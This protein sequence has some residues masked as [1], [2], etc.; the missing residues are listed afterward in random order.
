MTAARVVLAPT[1]LQ[2]AH[3]HL[4]PVPAAIVPPLT[5]LPFQAL[6]C[7]LSPG[8]AVSAPHAKLAAARSSCIQQVL[9]EPGAAACQ[10][11]LE[12]CVDVT[13]KRPAGAA[14]ALKT[15]QMLSKQSSGHQQG[16]IS[17]AGHCTMDRHAEHLRMCPHLVLVLAQTC[18]HLNSGRKLAARRQCRHP[19]VRPLLRSRMHSI[20]GRAGQTLL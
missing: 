8:A 17:P 1:S 2:S 11:K 3:A 15:E 5:R 19:L 16:H 7:C 4:P 20:G 9:Y 10:N 14:S 18:L 12:I 13:C 6:C